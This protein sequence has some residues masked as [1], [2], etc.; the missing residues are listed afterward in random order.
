M[1]QRSPEWCGPLPNLIVRPI[2]RV[3]VL[4]N[5]FEL[6]FV[7]LETKISR[8]KIPFSVPF[9]NSWLLLQIF[10]IPHIVDIEIIPDVVIFSNVELIQAV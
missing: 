2:Q 7:Y 8:T 5:W 1:L 9:G 6:E 4:G 3:L 10:V